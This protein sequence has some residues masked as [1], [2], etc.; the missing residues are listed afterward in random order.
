MSRVTFTERAREDLINIWL[1][2]AAQNLKRSPIASITASNTRAVCSRIIR[3]LGA[4]D[5]KSCRRRARSSSSAGLP[6]Y[7]VTEDGPKIVRI[8]DAARDLSA[9]EWSLE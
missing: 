3:S 9:I 8:I 5:L 4:R 7:R 2:V 6:L 1:Y